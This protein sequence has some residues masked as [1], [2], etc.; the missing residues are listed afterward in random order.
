MNNVGSAYRWGVRLL[1]ITLIA[2]VM[3]DCARAQ[4]ALEA[5]GTGGV[6]AWASDTHGY[7]HTMSARGDLTARW[8]PVVARAKLGLKRWGASDAILR[9][10]MLNAETAKVYSRRQGVS[11]GLR[12]DG[13]ELGVEYDRRS[14]HHVWRHK[15][16]EPRHDHFPG[17]WRDG[18]SGAAPD[19][20]R[21]PLYPSLGYW[22][23]LRPYVRVERQGLTLVWRGLLYHWKSLTLPWPAIRMRADYKWKRWRFGFVAQGLRHRALTGTLRV[24]RHVTGP[25][26]L[27]G[28]A[29]WVHPPQWQDERLRRLAFGLIINQ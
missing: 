17:S 6:M 21:S 26:W 3:V 5:H 28:G 7:Q 15:G 2:W 9:H 22:D 16:R 25:L 23:G 1:I 13:V 10:A 8:G 27:R 19:W 24:E 11:L 18:R 4:A 20:D 29:G 14:V 12:W